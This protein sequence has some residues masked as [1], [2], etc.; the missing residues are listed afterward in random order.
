[1]LA[2]CVEA[3]TKGERELT[4][5]KIEELV[6][7]IFEDK[8]AEKQFFNINLS[9]QQLRTIRSSFINTLTAIYHRRINTNDND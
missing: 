2:D 4:P 3:A 5:K 8:I 9:G 1:M 7:K 6:D